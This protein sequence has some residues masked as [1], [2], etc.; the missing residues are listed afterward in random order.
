M[1]IAG[2][3]QAYTSYS[4][5][6]PDGGIAVIQNN[7]LSFAIAEDRLTRRKGSGG[8]SAALNYYK[9]NIAK[10]GEIFDD[11]VLSSCCDYS[12]SFIFGN[13]PSKKITRCGHHRSHALGA[14]AW[15]GFNRA[16]VLVMDSGGDVLESV[17]DGK[18]WLSKREQ[19]SIF[20]IDGNEIRLL[21]RHAEDPGAIGFG[22]IFRAMTYFLGWHGARYAGNTMAAAA[23]APVRN[24]LSGFHFFEHSGTEFVF[25]LGNDPE[26]NGRLINDLLEK[27]NIFGFDQRAPDSPFSPKHFGIAAWLQSELDRYVELIAA[28]YCAMYETE[29]FILSGGV[30]YNCVSAGRLQKKYPRLNVFVH[31]ASGDVGQCLG[32][33]IDGYLRSTGKILRLPK[34]GVD[35]GGKYRMSPQRKTRMAALSTSDCD[36]PR[37]THLSLA[38][39]AGKVCALFNGRSEFGPRALGFRSILADATYPVSRARLNEIKSRNYMMP[40][41]P[42]VRIEDAA[43]YF[44]MAGASPYMA[45]TA[46]IRDNYKNII[47]SCSQGHGWARVQTVSRAENE[48]LHRILSAFSRAGRVPVLL[49]TSLNG[50]GEPIVESIDDLLSWCERIHIDFVWLNGRLYTMNPAKAEAFPFSRS[51]FAELIDSNYDPIE[52]Q[53]RLEIIFPHIAVRKRRRLLLRSDYVRWVQ[54]GRKTTTV[55]FRAG[56]VEVPA[57]TSLPLFASNRFESFAEGETLEIGEVFFTRATYKRFSELDEG[58]AVADGFRSEAELKNTLQQIYPALTGESMVSIFDISI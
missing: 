37:F 7:N 22:E 21:A 14:A 57:E 52:L 28:Q 40:V 17:V 25:P 48:A 4:K 23:L 45:K 51:K 5:S 11:L 39:A 27:N 13:L 20:L 58:D 55:R 2:C 50:P 16:I 49:N 31:P 43:V 41:A 32:N 34:Q 46:P 9:T 38:L 10:R 12:T 56:C 44:D 30:A 47:A 35:L 24:Q 1:I 54:E 18:W 53:E 8:F 3:N 26:K 15:S 6:L 42:V 33:A 36:D 19:H 29:N